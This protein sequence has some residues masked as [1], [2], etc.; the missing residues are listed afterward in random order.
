MAAGYSSGGVFLRVLRHAPS[1]LYHG[2]IVMLAR[3]PRITT[4]HS[5]LTLEKTLDVSCALVA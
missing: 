4:M 3:L 5:P 2:S 1:R